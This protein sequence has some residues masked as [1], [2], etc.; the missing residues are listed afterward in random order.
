MTATPPASRISAIACVGDRPASRDT[1]ALAPG[2]RY[3]SK[4][5]PRSPRRAGRLG[6]VGAADRVGV[7]GLA[8]RVLEG[9]VEAVSAQVLD[10]LLGPVAALLLGALAGGLIFSRSTQ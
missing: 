5:G 8:D 2:T 1:K 6:D 10:D 9:E 4:K 3:S 7:A